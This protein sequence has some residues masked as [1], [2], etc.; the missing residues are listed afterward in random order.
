MH[1]V[2]VFYRPYAFIA[3]AFS[4]YTCYL[5]ISWGSLYFVLTLLWIKMFSSLLLG[6]VFHLSRRE[7][8]YFY[9]N[10]GFSTIRLYSYALLLD[11]LI[12]LAFIIITSRFV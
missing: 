10:L 12:W 5:Y 1:P 8:L 7:Q 9:H 11:L 6:L 2:V 4:L 3:T